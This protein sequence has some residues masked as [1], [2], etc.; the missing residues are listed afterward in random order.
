MSKISAIILTN[1]SE[2]T[3]EQTLSSLTFCSEIIIVDS[4]STDSTLKIAKKYYAIVFTDTSSD[5]SQKRN[6][7][8]SKAKENWILYVDS[9]EVV[10]ESLRREVENVSET[11]T[12]FAAYKIKRKNFYL[13]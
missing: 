10:T 4:G 7:G 12:K 9:D 2:K 8:M 5:F 6:L 3:L 1:N 13:G 11:D